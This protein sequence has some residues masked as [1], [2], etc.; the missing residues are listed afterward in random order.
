M[1]VQVLPGTGS[2]STLRGW[3]GFG[4]KL[5]DTVWGRRQQEG[6]CHNSFLWERVLRGDRRGNTSVPTPKNRCRCW[7]WGGVG[8][9]VVGRGGGRRNIKSHTSACSFRRL[10][11]SPSHYPPCPSVILRSMYFPFSFFFF[12]FALFPPLTTSRRTSRPE[13]S[14]GHRGHRACR[15]CAPA[16]AP[17]RTRGG[18]TAGSWA[19]GRARRTRAR[20]EWTAP[21]CR[22]RT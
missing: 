2:D 7:G 17:R 3:G 10:F 20:R 4:E 19:G 15:R 1:E 21:T 14:P 16:S 5:E 22:P 11:L 13:P 9:G 8:G 6:L 18:R 12:L